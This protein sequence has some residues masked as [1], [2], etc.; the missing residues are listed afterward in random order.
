MSDTGWGVWKIT[1]V[2][3]PFGAGAA[4]VNLFFASLI[5]SWAGGP[6]LLP[7]YAILGG[8]VLGLPLT[9][10][11]AKHIRNLMNEAMD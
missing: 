11:F 2:L 1:A 8:L 6:V 7:T 4:G 3:Y 5:F 9:W 10:Q